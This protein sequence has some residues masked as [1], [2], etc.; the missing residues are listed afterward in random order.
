MLSL[1]TDDS[2][3]PKIAAENIDM[4]ILLIFLFNDDLTD[5]NISRNIPVNRISNEINPVC[6]P[7]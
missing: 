1:K 2:K 4:V 6:I 3:K 7:I 5:L